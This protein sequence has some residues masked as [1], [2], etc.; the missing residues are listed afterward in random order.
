M[1]VKFQ[2]YYLTLGVSRTATADEIR[3]AFRKL[4]RQ[5][6]PDVNKEPSAVERFKL[7]N[8]A[9]EVLSDADKRKKYDQFGQD[10]KNGQ[11]FTPPSG[12]GQGSRGA[13]GGN[14]F[15]GPRSTPGAGEGFSFNNGGPGGRGFSDFFEQMFGGDDPFERSGFAHGHGVGGSPAP[16]ASADVTAEMALSVQDL[17]TGGTRRLS[18]TF[19]D[20]T[21]KTLDV[22]VP[23][24]L[25]DGDTIRLGGQGSE[26]GRGGRGDLLLNVKV[27]SDDRFALEG[28]DVRQ[29]V[30]I[31]PWEAALGA[32]IDVATAAGVLSVS[33]PAGTSS[34]GKLRLRGRGLPARGSDAAGDLIL[35]LQIVVPKALSD[36]ERVAVEAWR[37]ASEWKPR[38]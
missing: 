3:S 22:K 26:N 5:F 24:G 6:H 1:A 27:L 37:D 4:A 31:A 2:D 29:R 18:L 33:V 13:G 9:Y 14:G 8:E 15:R 20:G 30:A 35:D 38:G 34:G 10:W 21:R 25:N 7:V 32:K 12:W 17:V 16:A 11:E 28:R 19:P 23:A 36:A